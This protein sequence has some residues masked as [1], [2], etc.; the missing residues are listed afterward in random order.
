ME[1]SLFCLAALVIILLFFLWGQRMRIHKQ[2]EEISGLREQS[3]QMELVLNSCFT[4]PWIYVPKDR[5]LAYLSKERVSLYPGELTLDFFVR[6]YIHA[7]YQD[8]VFAAVEEVVT[9]KSQELNVKVKVISVDGRGEQWAHIFGLPVGWD[10]E[11]GTILKLIGIN[12]YVTKEIQQELELRES[13]EFLELTMKNANIIPW[14]YLLDEDLL[15]SKAPSRKELIHPLPMCDYIKLIVHPEWRDVYA[16]EIVALKEGRRDFLDYKMKVLTD[17]GEYEWVRSVGMILDK[18]GVGRPLRMIGASYQIDQEMRREEQLNKL[19]NAEEANRLKTA[20]IANISHEIRTPLNAIVGFSQL[21]VESPEESAEFLPII[22]TNN[23]LLLK[24][25]EDI[26]DISRIESGDLHLSYREINLN[27]IFDNLY[28]TYVY[29]MPKEVQLIKK[30]PEDSLVMS[31]DKNRLMQIMNNFL[32]NAVKFTQYGFITMGY[33]VLDNVNVRF[34][35]HDTGKGISL[36]DQKVVFERFTKLDM[37]VQGTGLG[38]SV[39]EM[40]VEKM[41]GVIGVQSQPNQGSEFWF[42]LPIHLVQ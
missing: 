30:Y 41:G 19:R 23:N 33:E 21:M 9:G 24:L 37:F 8:K 5:L 22:E 28:N 39:C 42:M 29:Q 17:S 32:N 20:F 31:S 10:E 36:Q 25:V 15:I 18:D 2:D 7:D 6:N 26:L 35:V 4:F 34:Y 12:R 38:L 13:K 14:E 11:Q 40:I 27:D 16:Q 3:S 1:V